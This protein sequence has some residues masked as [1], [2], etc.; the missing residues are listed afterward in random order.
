LE[1]FNNEVGNLER[2]I[3]PLMNF[4]G[5]RN[6]FGA[7]L[8]AE[9]NF[10]VVSPTVRR[11]EIFFSQYFFRHPAEKILERVLAIRILTF[12]F[13]TVRQMRSRLWVA[14][15]RNPSVKKALQPPKLGQTLARSQMTPTNSGGDGE[16]F[17]GM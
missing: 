13:N 16:I 17:G 8:K 7:G 15:Q 14:W 6:P 12:K 4:G 9:L 11:R 2:N 3:L 5:D 10:R 1:K